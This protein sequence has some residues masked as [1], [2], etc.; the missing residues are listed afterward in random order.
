MVNFVDT[1]IYLGTA[2][3]TVIWSV[4]I[5]LNWMDR[6]DLPEDSPRR[7]LLMLGPS[8][9]F[10]LMILAG[11]HRA[12]TV[13]L[14]LIGLLALDALTMLCWVVL[15]ALQSLPG[16]EARRRYRSMLALYNGLAAL[17]VLVAYLA[18]SHPPLLAA[19]TSLI[20]QARRFD[21]FAFAWI[22]LDPRTH[23]ADLSSMLNKVL[24]ALLSYL[25]LSLI[26]VVALARQR[27]RMQREIDRLRRRIEAIERLNGGDGAQPERG[28]VTVNVVP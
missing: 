10:L 19:L 14:D 18:R 17:L 27:R 22:G 16:E 28:R 2:I 7:Y 1:G 13:R 6:V 23:E 4:W 8:A 12:R 15:L 5:Y 11:W 9:W 25:P 20:R 3:L 26:R 24:I 21:L